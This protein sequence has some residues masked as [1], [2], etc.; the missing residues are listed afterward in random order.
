MEGRWPGG[1]Q[2]GSAA[3]GELVRRGKK[4]RATLQRHHQVSGLGHVRT[5]GQ[6]SKSGQ[7]APGLTGHMCILSKRVG[8]TRPAIRVGAT[9]AYWWELQE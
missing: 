3:L 4:A 9:W 6:P 2:A 7:K 5:R 8:V 1:C